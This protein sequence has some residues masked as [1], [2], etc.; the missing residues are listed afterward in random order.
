[1]RIAAL[2]PSKLP[3]GTSSFN[4]F[5]EDIIY[6]FGFPDN[7][8]YKNALATMIMH[9]GPT[10]NRKSRA[11]FAKAIAKTA[12]NQI[13]YGVIEEIRAAYKAEEEATKLK[14]SAEATHTSNN[15]SEPIGNPTA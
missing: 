14:P 1:M 11:H 5:Y 15:V 3:Q 4:K 2:Y 8:S 12:A 13:A 9:L 7:R 10:C 6:A